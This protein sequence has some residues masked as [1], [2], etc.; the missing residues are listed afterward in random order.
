ML[1]KR[2]C[3]LLFCGWPLFAQQYTGPRPPKS[4]LPYLMHADNLVATESQ[5]AKQEERKSEV[6]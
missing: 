3:I 5:E 4:D 2:I 6:I 1:M